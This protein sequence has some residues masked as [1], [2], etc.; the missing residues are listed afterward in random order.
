MFYLFFYP[1]VSSFSAPSPLIHPFPGKSHATLLI[2][3]L[4]GITF[5]IFL[6]LPN[7]RS[8]GVETLLSFKHNYFAQ[9]SAENE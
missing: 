4:K 2:F 9:R 5:W 8:S 3:R 1:P 6:I 7:V